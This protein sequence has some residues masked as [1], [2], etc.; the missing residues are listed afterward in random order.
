MTRENLMADTIWEVNRDTKIYHGLQKFS[1]NQY[2]K[3]LDFSAIYTSWTLSRCVPLSWQYSK[4]EA[5][6]SVCVSST[7]C[8]CPFYKQFVFSG[9]M[10]CCINAIIISLIWNSFIKCWYLFIC[11][12]I[13]K[14]CAAKGTIFFFNSN[15]L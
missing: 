2:F 15:L 14:N 7:Y 8:L 11:R 10:I 13:I 12:E 6:A 1:N 5:S 9:K 3:M 4:N